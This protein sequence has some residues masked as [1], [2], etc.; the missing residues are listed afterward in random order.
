M[1]MKNKMILSA[2]A[3]TVICSCEQEQE[4]V[5]GQEH[6]QAAA[7]DGL[8]CAIISDVKTSLNA[9][10]NVVWKS[11]DAVMVYAASGASSVYATEDDNVTEA[12]FYPSATAVG[13]PAYAVYPSLAGGDLSGSVVKV[14]FS[15]LS[16][17]SPLNALGEGTDISFVPMLGQFSE[18]VMSFSNLCGGLKLQI[19]DYQANHL[20]LKQ[21][22]L[23]AM[24]IVSETEVAVSDGSFTLADSNDEIVV[25]FGSEGY[26]L[27]QSTYDDPAKFVI[28]LPAGTYPALEFELTDTEGRVM[29]I[30][31]SKSVTVTAGVVSSLAVRPLTLYHGQANSVVLAPGSTA[32][33]DASAYYT[34]KSDYTY[35]NRPVKTVG[36]ENWLPAGAKAEVI[37]EQKEGTSALTE[38]SVLSSVTLSGS[39]I[40]VVSNGTKGNALVAIKD[41]NDKILWSWHIWVSEVNDV[42]YNYTGYDPFSIHDRNLG[43]VSVTPKDFDA[44]GMFYQWGRKDPFPRPIEKGRTDASAGKDAELTGNSAYGAETG[45]I[46]YT[47]S[48][49]STRIIAASDPKDWHVARTNAL[50]GNPVKAASETDA[51]AVKGGVKTV[52]DPCPAGY[53]V[54]ELYYYKAIASDSDNAFNKAES[55]SNYGY[56]FDTGNS[57][58]SYWPTTGY[59]DNAADNM[60][61]SGYRAYVWS[62]IGAGDNAWY[63]YYNNAGVKMSYAVRA[64]AKA[65]R[66]LK[67]Q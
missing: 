64:K 6:Q 10:M 40:S 53:K 62:S 27:T 39:K 17:Q 21:L 45:V 51:V 34:F 65:V 33:V 29:S 30:A 52:Y 55:D 9:D 47:V 20:K 11:R 15:V 16:E 28:F 61:Y 23:K 43:A 49:P 54:P 50:W 22:K 37:W 5:T 66:C 26:D 2:L 36:G 48:N 58:D 63:F 18:N 67:I 46:A 14:D 8:T 12:V 13:E 19:W 56:L 7:A 35:E 4:L 32:L 3:L 1:I 38:G 31:S 59:L 57:I 42:S 44:F 41:G 60:L 25:D 24:G